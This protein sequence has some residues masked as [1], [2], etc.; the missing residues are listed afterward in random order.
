[1]C[2]RQAVVKLPF[3]DVSRLA[4]AA[5]EPAPDEREL[6]PVEEVRHWERHFGLA[7]TITRLS[8]VTCSITSF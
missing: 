3:A 2:A 5:Q 8:D 6:S 1:M 4:A 7:G